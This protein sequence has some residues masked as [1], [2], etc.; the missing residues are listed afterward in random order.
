MRCSAVQLQKCP[1]CGVQVSPSADGTCPSC[2]RPLEAAP[3]DAPPAAESEMPPAAE[4]PYVSP[5]AA[6]EPPRPASPFKAGGAGKPAKP[7]E[8]F[9]H[10]AAKFSAYAP[11]IL[12][13][14]SW[15]VRGQ[16]D[17]YEATDTGTQLSVA[18]GALAVLT[19]LAAF[20]LGIVGLVGGI[21]RR[22]AWTAVLASLGV[23]MNAG[24][25]TL[26]GM[27]IVAIIH[28]AR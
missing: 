14:M 10:Q 9:S 20:V 17:H 23:L 5:T 19:T 26:W 24:I 25:L 21:R 27:V 8:P 1:N 4:N 3:A 15:C 6:A 28:Q 13:L 11:F 22:A 18:I 12:L 2:R 16:F 7:K